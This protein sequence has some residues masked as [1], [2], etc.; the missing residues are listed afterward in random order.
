MSDKINYAAASII[1]GLVQKKLPEGS[2]H[3]DGKVLVIENDDIYKKAVFYAGGVTISS[4]FKSK[5][6][7]ELVVANFY[8]NVSK[9]GLGAI[10]DILNKIAEDVCAALSVSYVRKVD[11]DTTYGQKLFS[12]LRQNGWAIEPEAYKISSALSMKMNR[13][14]FTVLAKKDEESVALVLTDNRVS[15]HSENDRWNIVMIPYEQVLNILNNEQRPTP[16]GY[17]HSIK[18]ELMTMAHR[19]AGDL[20]SVL[21]FPSGVK[22]ATAENTIR[23][24]ITNNQILSFSVVTVVRLLA[25]NSTTKLMRRQ[26]FSFQTDQLSQVMSEVDN[27]LDLM[28]QVRVDTCHL[29]SFLRDDEIRTRAKKLFAGADSGFLAPAFSFLTGGIYSY[30]FDS[31]A[32]HKDFGNSPVQISWEFQD[33]PEKGITVDDFAIKIKMSFDG[34]VATGL[35][36]IESMIDTQRKLNEITALGNR[37]LGR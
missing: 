5:Y 14:H 7:N 29:H 3:M 20:E 26:E 6:K 11:I 25:E 9:Q 23:N 30:A 15:I 2:F 17:Y 19:K 24:V 13:H 31:E 34:D 18:D 8:F 28:N 36:E 16:F 35:D 32:L 27:Y 10:E 22:D 1:K 21:L 12:E 4:G 33:V 37:I